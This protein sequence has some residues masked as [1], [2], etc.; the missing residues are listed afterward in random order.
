M[1]ES[2]FGG[3]KVFLYKKIIFNFLPTKVCPPFPNIANIPPSITGHDLR[4]EK[5]ATVQH[6]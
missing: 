5:G 1:F 4:A 2:R 6:L 3:K